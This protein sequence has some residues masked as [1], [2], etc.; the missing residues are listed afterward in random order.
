MGQ[1]RDSLKGTFGDIE[2]YVGATQAYGESIRCI[3]R[4]IYIYIYIYRGSY[5]DYFG[6]FGE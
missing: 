3:Y 6:Y 4:Y 1:R 2:G 5:L